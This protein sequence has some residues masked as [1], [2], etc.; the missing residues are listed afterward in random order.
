V[1]VNRTLKRLEAEHL[2]SRGSPRTVTINDWGKLAQAGDF[3]STYLHLRDDDA[4][5]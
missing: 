5:A 1:H 4:R 2:I 3:D